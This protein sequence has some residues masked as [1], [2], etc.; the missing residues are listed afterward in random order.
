MCGILGFNFKDE[1]KA[2]EAG[3]LLRHRGPDQSGVF[4][5]DFVT[6]GHHRLS[7]IDL[8][9]AGRQP[10]Q[11]QD[12]EIVL[13][14]NGEIYNFQELKKPLA[15]KY[16][17]KSRSDTEAIIYGYKEE[18]INF[19]SKLRGMWALTLY[20]RKKR[21]LILAR[22]FFGIK[23]L[24]YS[25]KG[26][27]FYFASEL[28]VLLNWLKPPINELDREGYDFYF[29]FGYFPAPRTPFLNIKKLEPGALLIY[30]L[31]KKSIRLEKIKWPQDG[32]E[33]NK[34]QSADFVKEF[35]EVFKESV[36]AHFVS[37]VPISILFSGGNDSSLVAA[38]ALDSGFSP[39]AFHF[40]AEGKSDYQYAKAVSRHL[41]LKMEI[42]SANEA[43]I[44]RI[45]EEL[46]DWLDEPFADVSIIPAAMI[47]ALV[48]KEAKV[49][50]TGDGGDDLLGG[51]V[52]HRYFEDLKFQDSPAR[53]F[54][55]LYKLS[56]LSN[57]KNQKYLTPLFLRALSIMERKKMTDI[58]SAFLEKSALS[59]LEPGADFNELFYSLKK[60]EDRAGKAPAELF[61]DIFFYLK[62]DLMYKTDLASM[63]SSV[64]SRVPFLDKEIWRFL[65]GIYGSVK[66]KKY[67][68]NKLLVKE[69]LA[70][71]LP[72]NLVYRKKEGF[73]FS[74]KDY[75]DREIKEDFAE[76][77]GYYRKNPLNF[78]LNEKLIKSLASSG[79]FRE[80]I[81]K[82]YPRFVFGLISNY[83]F[84]KNTKIL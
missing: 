53:F 75:L 19:F 3:N 60:A 12:G 5:D 69:L 8:S 21:I 68:R 17:F 63:H 50:L 74:L 37:D 66:Q 10:M 35:K 80:I 58:T 70:E 67:F 62:N 57:L 14:F 22:D 84:L 28:K 49:A 25:Q 38:S 56:R 6:F 55:I 34:N 54:K 26:E 43:D 41:G 82:K 11:S 48:A 72:E 79:N 13:V 44:K 29:Q 2:E 15:Q 64:E 1:K 83:K 61:Y 51:Y 73:S 71:Y 76:C 59:H 30:D 36:K 46:W 20:D 23:P 16:N 39:R 4:S 27:N 9:K 31:N 7:I 42:L 33:I 18:G 40:Q 77:L 78:G 52:R 81:F 45:Y 47:Y 65:G 24:L 32:G